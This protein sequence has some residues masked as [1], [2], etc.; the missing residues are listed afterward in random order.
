M[1]Y[2]DNVRNKFSHVAVTHSSQGAGE[3]QD[4]WGRCTLDTYSEPT[5]S[6]ATG[7]DGRRRSTE[8]WQKKKKKMAK[9]KKKKKGHLNCV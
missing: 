6:A 7:G 2:S 3:G 4:V 9:S 8:K 1:K 5:T